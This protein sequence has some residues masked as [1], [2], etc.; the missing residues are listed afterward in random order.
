MGYKKSIL[1]RWETSEEC[2]RILLNFRLLE[3]SKANMYICRHRY[4]IGPEG[5]EELTK[6]AIYSSPQTAFWSLA[7]EA[8]LGRADASV[9]FVEEMRSHTACLVRPGHDLNLWFWNFFH[10]RNV[11]PFSRTSW[12]KNTNPKLR[13]WK[14]VLG[15]KRPDFY[16]FPFYSYR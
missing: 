15:L 2:G 12:I 1:A 9:A 6:F 7:L 16:N 10:Y 11:V 3:G 4:R 8:S 5:A 13:I 14:E